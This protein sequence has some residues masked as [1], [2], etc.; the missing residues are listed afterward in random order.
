MALSGSFVLLRQGLAKYEVFISTHY[1]DRTRDTECR[2]C[3]GVV[4][5]YSRLLEIPS[6]EVLQCQPSIVVTV[7]CTVSEIWQNTGQKSRS[8]TPLWLTP[9]EF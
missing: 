6:Y 3:H 2:K 8:L 5:G 4:R 7:S 1:E 9:L